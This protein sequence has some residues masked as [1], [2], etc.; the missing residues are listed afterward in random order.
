M[1]PELPHAPASGSSLP[2]CSPLP[3]ALATSPGHVQ[4]PSFKE[5]RAK[6]TQQKLGQAVSLPTV[7]LRYL[8]A[9]C[10]PP[11]HT[12]SEPRLCPQPGT[13]HSPAPSVLFQGFTT[14]CSPP[15]CPES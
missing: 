8:L 2:P 14:A 9:P 11:Q 3:K 6:R 12:P 5:K 13:I 15:G 4:P 10:P 1:G 7:T